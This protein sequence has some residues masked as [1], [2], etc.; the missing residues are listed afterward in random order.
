VLTRYRLARNEGYSFFRSLS[1]AVFK[2]KPPQVQKRL[3][4]SQVRFAELQ[5]KLG[6]KRK[7]APDI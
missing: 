7:D 1:F 2:W 6:A 3:H 4:E 5:K